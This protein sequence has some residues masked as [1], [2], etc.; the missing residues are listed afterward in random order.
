MLEIKSLSE[1]RGNTVPLYSIKSLLNGKNFPKF[2]IISGREGVGKSTVCRLV[3]EELNE[4]DSDVV[5]YNFGLDIKMEDLRTEVFSMAPVRPKAFIFE[6]IQ[7]LDKVGQTALLNMIDTQPQNVYVI[8]TTTA[9]YKIARALRSRA[10]VW[11]FKSLSKVQLSELL[12]DY[13]AD[14]G[15]TLSHEAK[16]ILIKSANG[17]PRDLLKNTDFALSG[18]FTSNDLS[19]LLGQVPDDIMFSLFVAVASDNVNIAEIL[20][21]FLEQTSQD[22]VYQLRDYW[23]RFI[24]ESIAEKFTTIDKVHG[25]TLNTVYND[26]KRE[27]MTKTLIRANA[28]TLLL[29]LL[30]LNMQFLRKSKSNVLGSQA[31]QAQVYESE[32]SM[33]VN[34]SNVENSPS[35]TGVDAGRKLSRS[36]L[37]ELKL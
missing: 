21:K 18:D 24:L 3:A 32:M 11:D 37:S 25:R 16:E 5:V 31:H 15:E 27:A 13:L 35:G 29:E 10:T 7:G 17:V 33:R 8:C 9:I 20:N 30:S 2:S 14:R 23:T 4:M 36:T 26:S 19:T 12:D 34:R 6:E 22:K 28:D 1:V